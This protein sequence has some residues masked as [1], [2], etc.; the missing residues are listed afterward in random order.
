MRFLINVE[1]RQEVLVSGGSD[2]GEGPG[3]WR[4]YKS[5]GTWKIFLFNTTFFPL[6]ITPE[7]PTQAV[8]SGFTHFW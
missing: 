4:V 3:M 5:R 7:S 2:S 1:I 6:S 8:I